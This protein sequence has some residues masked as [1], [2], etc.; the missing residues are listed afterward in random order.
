MAD[1]KGYMSRFKVLLLDSFADPWNDDSGFDEGGSDM[2]N[3]R[4][5]TL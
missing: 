5:F 1:G 4:I 3:R 2:K